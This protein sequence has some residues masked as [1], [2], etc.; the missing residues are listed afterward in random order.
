[1][2]PHDDA[3][4]AERGW[5]EWHGGYARGRTDT[6]AA[7]NTRGAWARQVAGQ[8]DAEAEAG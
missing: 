5:A 8:H 3:R 7:W 1:V 6:G 4:L 2:R